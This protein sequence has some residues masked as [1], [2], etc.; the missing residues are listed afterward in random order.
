MSVYERKASIRE[1]Q[2]M[3]I[4]MAMILFLVNKIDIV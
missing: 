1:F 2:G 4:Y 3:L